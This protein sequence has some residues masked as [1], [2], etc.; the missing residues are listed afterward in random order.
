MYLSTILCPILISMIPDEKKIESAL[1]G[2]LG[3]LII[4]V[5]IFIINYIINIK[6]YI[7]AG[8]IYY[9]ELGLLSEQFIKSQTSE[10]SERKIL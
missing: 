5:F 2:C 6:K 8:I 1:I 9:L 10:E 4:P 3:I 7:Y